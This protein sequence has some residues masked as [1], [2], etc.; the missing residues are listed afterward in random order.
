MTAT[1]KGSRRWLAALTGGMLLFVAACSSSSSSDSSSGGSAA[2]EGGGSAACAPA[3]SGQKVN[4]TFYSWIPGIEKVVATWNAANPDIQVDVKTG[5]SGN[6]GAY[7]NFSNGIK[8]GNAPDLMQIEFDRLPNFRIQDGL[9]DIGSCPGVADAK[10]Q[11]VNWTWSQ[12]T[13][14]EANSVYAIPQDTGP[15]AFFYRKDLFTAAGS[16]VPTTW[17]EFQTAAQAIKAKGAFITNFSSGDPNQF[18][19]F[20]W[21]N[22]GQ[23]FQSTDA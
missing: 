11:F 16:P 14:G 13:F 22:Q 12:A 8:A 1:T 10:S 23:W 9:A 3:P 20:V 5:P 17:A 21:Q 19:G 18:A 6:G 7:Q 15:L 4:L 2:A